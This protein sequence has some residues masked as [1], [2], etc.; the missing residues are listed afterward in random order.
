MGRYTNLMRRMILGASLSLFL[1]A[2][3][4]REVNTYSVFKY[5]QDDDVAMKTMKTAGN[6][7]PW[8]VEAAAVGAFYGTIGAFY[9]GILYVESSRG[10]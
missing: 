8:T 7:L 10:Y 3:T 5:R 6:I 9:L 1:S 4:T 2:C